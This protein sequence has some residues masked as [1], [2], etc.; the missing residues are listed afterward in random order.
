MF[1]Y[2]SIE[3]F[4]TLHCVSSKW[5]MVV[6]ALKSSLDSPKNY[7]RSLD[8]SLTYWTFSPSF[9]DE[10]SLSDR[11]IS[12]TETLD[13]PFTNLCSS[14]MYQSI[15]L[16]LSDN[17]Y[18]RVAHCRSLQVK[19]PYS[20]TDDIQEFYGDSHLVQFARGEIIAVEDCEAWRIEKISEGIVHVRVSRAGDSLMKWQPCREE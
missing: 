4:E 10:R 9:L 16:G 11:S 1:R 8:S 15:L 13:Q 19:T 3:V 7:A 6:Q 12:R 14:K 17:E 18:I 20:D 5:M 2:S